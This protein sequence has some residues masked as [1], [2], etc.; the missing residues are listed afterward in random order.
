MEPEV[1]FC[2]NHV[3]LLNKPAGLL[4]QPN[5]TTA[6]S[7]EAWGKRYL[8]ERFKKPGNVF[9]EAVH[10]LDRPV[11][12][13]VLFARTS[14]ALRRLQEAQ[15]ED[16]FQKEYLA[17]VEGSVS[18]GEY[19]DHLEHGEGRAFR[20]QNGKLSCLKFRALKKQRDYTLVQVTLLT[21]RYHQIR[22]QFASRGHPVLGDRKYG[23][24]HTSKTLFLHHHAFTFPHPISGERSTYYA[25]LPASWT[26]YIGSPLAR[27]FQS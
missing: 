24:S 12:G 1:I 10:R 23:S 15:R 3:L 7:L 20:S 26:A 6:D 9:L 19:T 2:D 14:K 11:S 17:L 4:T 8:K 5:Q 21:G 16:T 25:P 18:D 27:S 13:L 22:V